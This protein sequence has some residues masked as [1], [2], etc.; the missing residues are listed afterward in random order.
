MLIFIEI[1][2]TCDFSGG[3]PDPLYPSGSAHAQ[4]IFLYYVR[5]CFCER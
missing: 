5:V 3:G 2:I 1:H 4:N